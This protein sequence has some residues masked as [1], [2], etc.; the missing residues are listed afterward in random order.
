MFS[1]RKAMG[2]GVAV[3]YFFFPPDTEHILQENLKEQGVEVID[4]PFSF[5]GLIIWKEERDF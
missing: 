1:G 4:F 3:G 5:S 2:T